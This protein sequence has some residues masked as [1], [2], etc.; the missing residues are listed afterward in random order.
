M[1]SPSAPTGPKPEKSEDVVCAKVWLKPGSEERV[2]AWARHVQANRGAAMRSLEDEGVTIESVFFDV[3][4]GQPCLIYYMRSACAARAAAVARRST[5]AI[6]AYHQA[7]KYDT[8]V[9]VEQLEL[10]VD[11]GQAPAP[12]PD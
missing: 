7:F 2:R 8:W 12:S 1:T 4:D 6:D 3:G 11:L 9:R 10:L 5:H